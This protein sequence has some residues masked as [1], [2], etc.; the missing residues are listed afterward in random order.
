MEKRYKNDLLLKVTWRDQDK[1]TT[2]DARLI[3]MKKRLHAL[4][5]TLRHVKPAR[6]KTQINDFYEKDGMILD[7]GF[8]LNLRPMRYPQ[9]FDMYRDAIKNTWT[10]EKINLGN[11]IADLKRLT[12]AEQHLIKRLVAFLR[13]VIALWRT[14]LFLIF[15]NISTLQKQDCICQ[16]S[17]SKKHCMYNF[18]LHCSILI[19]KRKGR[20][21]A[22][23]AVETIPS[24]KQK[25]DFCFKYM[26]TTKDYQQLKT[27]DKRNFY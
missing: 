27:D 4:L 13:L 16:D 24:I 26:D 19:C 7:T 15:T 8:D 21:E 17:Y 1:K 22:F 25:A 14:M 2:V 6:N 23:Q 9:F 3:Q 11:D 10:V 5:R 18:I 20:A 12:D